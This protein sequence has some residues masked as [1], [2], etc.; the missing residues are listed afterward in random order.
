MA[1]ITYVDGQYHLDGRKIDGS[2]NTIIYV[3][4]HMEKLRPAPKHD[5]V[6]GVCRRAKETGRPVRIAKSNA[7]E[8]VTA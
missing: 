5:F 2:A 8:W 3:L 1:E 6:K 7:G 4:R